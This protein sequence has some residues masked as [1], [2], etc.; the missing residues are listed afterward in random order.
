MCF[1]HCYLVV[2]LLLFFYRHFIFKKCIL[3]L[4]KN[5]NICILEKKNVMD[6]QTRELKEE[7]KEVLNVVSSIESE[8]IVLY[9]RDP[10]FYELFFLYGEKGLGESYVKEYC[11]TEELEGLITIVN[12]ILQCPLYKYWF[13]FYKKVK[14]HFH[15]YFHITPTTY[16]IDPVILEMCHFEGFSDA[17]FFTNNKELDDLFEKEVNTQFVIQDHDFENTFIE[18]LFPSKFVCKY[19]DIERFLRSKKMKIHH[20]ERVANEKYLKTL[21]LKLFAKEEIIQKTSKKSYN[22]FHYYISYIRVL[23]KNE[24]LSINQIFCKK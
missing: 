3:F 9:I 21:D 8:N 6:F 13:I 18:K 19:Q 1:D 20:L 17:I 23:L 4:F 11:F 14:S 2:F 12:K 15:K 22:L 10:L 5:E 7:T 16:S 24:H